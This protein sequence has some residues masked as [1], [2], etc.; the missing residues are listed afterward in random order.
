MR[1]S[2]LEQRHYATN[3]GMN[4]R[5]RQIEVCLVSARTIWVYFRRSRALGVDVTKVFVMIAWG[6]HATLLIQDHF[7]FDGPV[8]NI[9]Y[10]FVIKV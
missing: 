7:K 2:P 10:E 4:R 1:T 8:L 5:N 3:V 9:S 6:S